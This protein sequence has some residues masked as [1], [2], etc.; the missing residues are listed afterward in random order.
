MDVSIGLQAVIIA[1]ASWICQLLRRKPLA[2]L[3][4]RF[5]VRWLKELC[6]GGLVGSALMFVP[7]FIMWIFGWVDW[8]W[9]PAGLSILVSLVLLFAGVAV[10]KSCCFEVSFFNDSSQASVSGQHN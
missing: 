7:S 6:L 9:N 10:A 1:L 4:G 2:E 5:N 8:Q 3:L